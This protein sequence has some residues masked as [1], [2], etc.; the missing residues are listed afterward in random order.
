MSF[1][2]RTTA[3]QNEVVRLYCQFEYNGRLMNPAGQPLVEIIDTDGVT[4]LDTVIAQNEYNGVYYADWYVP[5]NL[6]LGSYYDRWTFQWSNST[7]VTE[8]NM[9]FTVHG[10]ESYINFISPAISHSISQRAA[11]LMKDLSNEFIYEAMHIP[12]YWEQAM[13]VQQENQA[14]RVKQYYYIVLDA[15][16]YEVSEGAVYFNNG[17]KFTV[18]QSIVP[19]YSTSSSESSSSSSESIS[20]SSSSSISD[21]L[22]SLSSESSLS[23]SSSSIDS[24]S[25]SSEI[26]TTTTTT[27]QW[28]YQPTLTTVGTGNPSTSGTLT[29]ISGNGPTTINFV[30]YTAKTSRFSTVY[31]LAYKHQWNK[32]PR[33]IVRVNNRIV[34]DGWIVDWNGRIYFDGLM[35]PEDSVNM[36]YNFAYFSD[37]EILSFLYLGLQIMNSQPPA[38][39]VY[40]TLDSM[41][42]E[43]NAP[44]L[45][46]AAITALK[47]LIFG[48]NF[49]EKMVIFGE[50]DQARQAIASFQQLYQDYSTIWQETAKNAKTRK[51]YGMSQISVPEY[52]LPGGRCMSSDTSISCKI[53]NGDEQQLTI[54]EIFKLFED[55]NK[56]SVLSLL[57]NWTLNYSNV[58]KVWFS[59]KKKTYILKTKSAQIRLTEEHLVYIP[60]DDKYKPVMELTS[61][62]SIFVLVNNKLEEQNLLSKPEYY[63]EEEVY[64]IEVPETENFIGNNIV[65]HNSRWFR[66]LYK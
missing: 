35:A 31:S 52:T 17:Q 10:L 54:L 56:I 26:V 2:S 41:P 61:N 47:R 50:P 20:T 39:V 11:Q 43:W 24:L 53:N 25:S 5:A 36:T 14:K 34:D 22:S 42:G 15:D 8:Q 18:W 6:P 33:P 38:S 59:G 46:Y 63:N 1:Q 44:V 32:D 57:D 66:Y 58:E 12:V 21:S 28:V 3:L 23:S 27:T 65:S 7:G 60:N 9:L 16:K 45:L 4:V 13:R 37:E 40:T 48:L 62:D 29:K 19:F 55:D 64:D 49:Q 51:L 30:S